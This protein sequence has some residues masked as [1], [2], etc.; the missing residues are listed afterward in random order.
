M[1]FQATLF[2]TFGSL[3]IATLALPARAD[4][5][6]AR[7]DIYPIGEDYAS[8]SVPCT[9]SQQQG[10]IYIDRQDGVS[11]QLS[12]VGSTPGNFVDQYGN[13]A[14]RQAG[15][16]DAGQIYRLA[17]ESVYVYWNSGVSSAPS[18]PA[19][20]PSSGGRMATLNARD[21]GARINLRQQPT[22]N[23]G[24]NGYGLVGDRVELLECRQDYD[25]PGSDLNWCEV[26][27]PQS[28]AIGWIRSDFIIFPSDG[29]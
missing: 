28:G 21:P 19:S 6:S 10:Y 23:S 4:S 25:T 13:A 1:K 27:F 15:L 14:Y 3:A 2:A 12:P 24:T 29:F 18:T 8:A 16:G 20:S 22:V 5:V 26:R 9:F 17:N 11:Y 7:C